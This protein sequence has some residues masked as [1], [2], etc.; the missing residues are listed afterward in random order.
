MLG[1]CKII[2]PLG[3][4]LLFQ[5]SSNKHLLITAVHKFARLEFSIPKAEG[6]TE[7]DAATATMVDH[8]IDFILV[9][10]AN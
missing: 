8:H 4:E 7:T 1:G 10:R 2:I 3:I 6:Q 9:Q 5:A